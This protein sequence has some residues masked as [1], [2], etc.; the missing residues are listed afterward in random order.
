MLPPIAA[1]PEAESDVKTRQ[2]RH[3]SDDHV[4]DLLPAAAHRAAQGNAGSVQVA[5]AVH[6]PPTDAAVLMVGVVSVGLVA[7]TRP[8]ALP[9]LSGTADSRF[10]DVGVARNAFSVLEM[11]GLPALL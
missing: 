3:R 11:L 4:V 5:A 10:A 9:V 8:P 2:G 1:I 7:K 6:V